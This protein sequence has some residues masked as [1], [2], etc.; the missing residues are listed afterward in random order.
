[1]GVKYVAVEPTLTT[2]TADTTNKRLITS[3][4]IS[5][6]MRIASASFASSTIES[7]TS[8]PSLLSSTIGSSLASLLE[9]SRYS[10]RLTPISQDLG[11]SGHKA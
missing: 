7:N 6:S 3:L 5:V 9:R 2:A 1:M 11:E 4:K 8:S 10:T